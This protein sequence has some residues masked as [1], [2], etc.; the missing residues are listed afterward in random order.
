MRDFS[1]PILCEKCRK[2]IKGQCYSEIDP[3]TGY[4]VFY[5]PGC[6]PETAS[7]IEGMNLELGIDRGHKYK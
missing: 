2:E 7:E 1:S 3:E 5:H 6:K 4:R